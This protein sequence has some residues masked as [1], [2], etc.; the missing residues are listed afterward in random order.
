MATLEVG[1]NSYATLGELQAYIDEFILDTTT[2]NALTDDMKAK[3]AIQATRN[4]DNCILK[5]AKY[6][7]EQELAFPRTWYT[8][9]DS[10]GVVPN[11]VKLAQA[12]ECIDLTNYDTSTQSMLAKGIKS[13]SMKSGSVTF[14][15]R[16]VNQAKNGKEL[17]SES[18][19]E[20][21]AYITL[22]GRC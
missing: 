3:Y 11:R 19:R 14:S 7:V 4:I 10:A 21:R 9:K 13:K 15:D 17:N 8:C 6:D 2:W 22:A 18:R 12:Y 1:T 20:L 16:A 5:G